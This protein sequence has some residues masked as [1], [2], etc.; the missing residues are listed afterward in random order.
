MHMNILIAGGCDYLGSH[1]YVALRN[2][3]YHPVLLGEFT[4]TCFESLKGLKKLLGCEPRFEAGH[5]QNRTW[6]RQQIKRFQPFCTIYIEANKSSPSRPLSFGSTTDEGIENLLSLMRAL[7]ENSCRK[8]Q[9]A[10]SSTAYPKDG[11]NAHRENVLLSPMLAIDH[12]PVLQ[13]ELIRSVCSL[14]RDWSAAILRHFHV[15]GAHPSGCIGEPRGAGPHSLMSRL[16]HAAS[17]EGAIFEMD[18]HRNITP[19]GSAVRD[20]VH[21]Q[22]VAEAH[23]KA[24]DTLLEYQDNFTVNIG[25]G[26][27]CSVHELLCALENTSGRRIPWK[28]S[29]APQIEPAYCVADTRLSTE[30][31]SWRPQL[32]TEII[33]AD[34]WHW[35]SRHP[36]DSLRTHA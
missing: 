31:L 7:D 22:D 14:R 8:I 16:I 6:L 9:F 3:G 1:I 32:S 21:V 13:E 28:Y 4:A 2:A 23:V 27:A 25:T 5:L 15:M 20:F 36:P 29:P 35:H 17:T 12:L 19:D 11:K 30:L 24:L 10:S 33:C 34:A 26:R 18:C